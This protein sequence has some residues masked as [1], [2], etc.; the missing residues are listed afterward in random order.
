M[1]SQDCLQCIQGPSCSTSFQ[2][3]RMAPP[4]THRV[5]AAMM[6]DKKVLL[7]SNHGVTVAAESMDLAFSYMV[8]LV[9][10][11]SDAQPDQHRSGR[12]ILKVASKAHQQL[13]ACCLAGSTLACCTQLA[14][15]VHV[16][17]PAQRSQA[18][19]WSTAGSPHVERSD[20]M[21]FPC[22]S[23]STTWSVPASSSLLLAPRG[24]CVRLCR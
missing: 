11:A 9:V 19:S 2:S 20:L 13:S 16:S 3:R 8:S 1:H 18:Y 12:L 7:Q 22:V 21:L 17:K 4:I 10:S 24:R 5:C 14:G 6:G 23:C 15:S